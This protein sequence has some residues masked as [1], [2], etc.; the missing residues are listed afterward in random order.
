MENNP[1]KEI[2]KSSLVLL[3]EQQEDDVLSALAGFALRE[4]NNPVKL[5]A[6]TEAIEIYKQ[7]KK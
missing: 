1:Y 5:E 4:I 2:V 7:T 3:H 6:V